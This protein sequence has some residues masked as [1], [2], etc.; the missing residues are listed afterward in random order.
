MP[1]P[2]NP[3]ACPPPY[4]SLAERLQE[5]ERRCAAAERELARVICETEA[6]A[7][8]AASAIARL[9]ADLDKERARANEFEQ[10]M[11]A[12]GHEF[13]ILNATATTLAEHARV[14]P[15]ELVELK[16]MWAR[17]S[18][19]PDHAAV[20]LHQS[21]PDFLLKAARTAFRK[22]L[23]PDTRPAHEKDAAEA[24]FKRNEAAFER[25]F[26]MRG[27]SR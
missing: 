4:H 9:S 2:P 16:Q 14:D 21:A 24:A 18:A 19:D 12:M 20:G 6:E 25:L 1:C 13:A 7:K 5:A 22:S 3:P 8:I 11:R 27:L 17:A 15:P 26:R 10:I 23:H